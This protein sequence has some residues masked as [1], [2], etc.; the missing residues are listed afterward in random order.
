MRPSVIILTFNSRETIGATLA[1]AS[2]VSG[3]IHIV[4]SHS[5]D[6]TLQ[7]AAGFGCRVVQRPFANYA[8]QRN[9]AIENLPLRHPWQLHLDADERLTDAL[10]DEIRDLPDE[11]DVAGF[12]V[13]RL[14]YFLG[15]PIR[16]GGHYPIYH[17][18]LFRSGCAVVEARLYDQHFL[19]TGK[20]A[21]LRHPMIDDIRLDLKEWTDRH[22]RWAELEADE[23]LAS[24][25]PSA[26]IKP[27]LFDPI[28]RRRLYRDVYSRLPLGVRPY[29]LFFYR[30]VLRL[31][32]LDGRPGLIFFSLQSL[33]FRMLVDAKIYERQLRGRNASR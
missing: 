26:T 7:I 33:W 23:S 27:G 11:P 19:L 6:D 15:S 25:A 22:N 28:A 24:Q 4:D 10:V 29:L 18:R 12:L 14:T 9:W 16:H 3:D 2:K 20:S 5:T 1:S 8:D 21:R 17:M 32:F 31:G 13:P 30:Y